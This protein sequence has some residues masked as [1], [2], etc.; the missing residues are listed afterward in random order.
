MLGRD[1]TLFQLQ[2]SRYTAYDQHCVFCQRRPTVRQ[3]PSALGA[4]QISCLQLSKLNACSIIARAPCFSL[5]QRLSTQGAN[6]LRL[7][8]APPPNLLVIDAAAGHASV[9]TAPPLSIRFQHNPHA[10]RTLNAVRSVL[11]SLAARLFLS[12]SAI[13]DLIPITKESAFFAERF[14]FYFHR[15][16]IYDITLLH[17]QQ[18][19][20]HLYMHHSLCELPTQLF[21]GHF[22]PSAST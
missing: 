13:F 17:G 10:I 19:E 14:Y 4:S 16:H 1:S 6:I 8:T 2:T 20:S 9:H 3:I 5:H 21:P 22:L 12:C 7:I 15:T 18:R 11:S